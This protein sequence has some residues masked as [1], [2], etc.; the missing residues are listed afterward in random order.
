MAICRVGKFE[1]ISGRRS[2]FSVVKELAEVGILAPS[3][4]ER[5]SDQRHLAGHP[6]YNCNAP[7]NSHV[8]L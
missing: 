1:Y 8:S 7:L 3:C 6:V 4:I 2:A 5:R